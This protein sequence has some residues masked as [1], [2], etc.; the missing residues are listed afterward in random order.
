[1]LR[2]ILAA[3]ALRA[4]SMT[5]GTKKLYRA[6]GNKLGGKNRSGAINKNYIARANNNLRLIEAN[7]AIA[8]GMSVL[9][10][11]TGWV[12]W[13]SLFTRVFYDVEVTLFDVWD[14]R[15]FGGF[16]NHA[17]QLRARLRSEVDRPAEAIDRA[18]ALLDEVLQL[19]DFDSVYRRLGFRY[20]VDPTGSLKAVADAS[21]DL[22]I[23]SDV[24]EHVHEGAVDTLVGDMRRVLKPE[25]AASHQ[26][27]MADHLRIYDLKMPNKNYIRYGDRTWR[28]FFENDV[29]YINRIQ[30]S[31]WKQR[32]A[33]GG[34]AMV[35]EY[36]TKADDMDRL[37][38]SSRFAHYTPEDLAITV[39]NVL[40]R[41]SA[42]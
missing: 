18:E 16:L 35:S 23:S 1:L 15:Q 29:Q 34:L 2:Y 40:L 28:L 3:Q 11:G 5:S 13:E 33:Q 32:F 21:I 7:G 38:V 20:V 36:V 25:G 24:L 37:P 26:I 39:S 41:K 19:P 30:H 22:I 14:N 8:D 12:H 42:A 6:I 10:L 17:A 27:V 31:E 9:E 4:F